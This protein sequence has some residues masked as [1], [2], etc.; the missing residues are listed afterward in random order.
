VTSTVALVAET[1]LWRRNSVSSYTS[2]SFPILMTMKWVAVEDIRIIPCLLV[3]TFP[4]HS[5]R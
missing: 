1:R 3:L 4:L 5:V 2:L